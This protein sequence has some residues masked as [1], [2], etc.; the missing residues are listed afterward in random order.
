M[1][2]AAGR[3]TRAPTHKPLHPQAGE[4]LVHR[5]ARHLSTVCPAV[6]V[7]CG[8]RGDEV[9]AALD[10]LP[11]AVPVLGADPDAPMLMSIRHGL[12]AYPSGWD[13]LLLTPVDCLGTRPRILETLLA[14]W[15]QEPGRVAVPTHA[16]RRGHPVLLPPSLRDPIL[17]APPEL[18]LRDLMDEVGRLHV[19][20]DDPTVLSDLD[21][22]GD[23]AEWLEPPP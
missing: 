16:G 10:D 17:A 12:Q 22:A 9:A 18:S 20:I 2:L 6:Y 19:P 1:V 11:R 23:F 15:S 14:A 3:S 8:H 7:V 13:G 5:A 21:T 4:P